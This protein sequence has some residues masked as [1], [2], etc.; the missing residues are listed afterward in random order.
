M[1][2]RFKYIITTK[3]DHRIHINYN[4]KDISFHRVRL[5]FTNFMKKKWLSI[6]TGPGVFKGLKFEDKLCQ[7]HQALK[8][9]SF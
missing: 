5:C 9:S 1:N 4:V 2:G 3:K 7:K 6:S 8:E